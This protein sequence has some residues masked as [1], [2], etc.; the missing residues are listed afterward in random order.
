MPNDTASAPADRFLRILEEKSNFSRCVCAKVAHVL[1]IRAAGEALNLFCAL[2]LT[3]ASCK[4][5]ATLRQALSASEFPVPGLSFD[6]PFDLLHSYLRRPKDLR[7]LVINVAARPP[8]NSDP[9]PG[10]WNPRT[11][12]LEPEPG[13]YT[14][15]VQAPIAAFPPPY[16]CSTASA[17]AALGSL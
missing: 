6:V 10:T 14:R 17:S 11:W 4:T 3:G 1:E 2:I 12:N 16:E 8:T 7:G 15:P 9:K 13:T 5:A